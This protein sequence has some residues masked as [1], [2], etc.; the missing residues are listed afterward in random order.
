[1]LC[2][3]VPSANNDYAHEVSSSSTCFATENFRLI[4]TPSTLINLTR[5]KPE[6]VRVGICTA[7]LLLGQ[8]KIS[9]DFVALSAE[10]CMAVSVSD[11]ALRARAEDKIADCDDDI[12]H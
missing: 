2:R 8:T 11:V 3:S 7:L 6:I 10:R 12:L 1:M 9:A 4:V 5:S